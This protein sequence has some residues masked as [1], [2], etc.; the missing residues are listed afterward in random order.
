MGKLKSFFA[1][2]IAGVGI[3]FYIIIYCVISL[4]GIALVVFITVKVLQWMGVI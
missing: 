1:G 2:I 4:S 3:L